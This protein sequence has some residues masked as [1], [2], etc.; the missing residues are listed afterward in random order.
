ME[1]AAILQALPRLTI[2]QRLEIADA[3]LRLVYQEQHFTRDQRRQQM[4]IAA[5]SAVNDYAPGSELIVF[6]RLDGED[7][8][9]SSTTDSE[10]PN[11]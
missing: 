8:Y 10:N 9:N 3:A 1:T 7:F 2:D 4:A 11:A 6:T 5:M